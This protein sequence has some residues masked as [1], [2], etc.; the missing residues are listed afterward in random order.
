MNEV[1]KIMVT[2]SDENEALFTVPYDADMEDLVGIFRTILYWLTWNTD[3]IN[4]NIPEPGRGWCYLDE[5]GKAVGE[6][7][8]SDLGWD[9]W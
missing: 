6:R 1:I 3:T 9:V 2:D 8:T 5:M 4:E 7:P